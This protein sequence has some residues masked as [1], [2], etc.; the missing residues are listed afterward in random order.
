[1][2]A[3]LLVGLLRNETLVQALGF[4][5]Y[6]S[7]DIRLYRLQYWTT[8]LHANDDSLHGSHCDLQWNSSCGY[9]I[10]EVLCCFFNWNSLSVLRCDLHR[11]FP[12][13]FQSIANGC[14]CNYPEKILVL[15]TAFQTKT[16][17]V[18]KRFSHNCGWITAKAL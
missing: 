15:L 10:L 5:H 18:Y 14:V 7:L 4:G 11:I 12:H 17:T 6:R 2:F 3:E 13:V 16:S 8:Q 1:M 9:L